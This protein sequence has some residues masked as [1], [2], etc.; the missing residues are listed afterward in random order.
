MNKQGRGTHSTKAALKKMIADFTKRKDGF[1]CMKNETIA[2]RLSKTSKTVANS[3]SMLKSNNEIEVLYIG[4]TRYLKLS[5][6]KK[7]NLDEVKKFYSTSGTD[8]GCKKGTKSGTPYKEYNNINKPKGSSNNNNKSV[9]PINVELVNELQKELIDF[10]GSIESYVCSVSNE[11]LLW[12]VINRYRKNKNNNI[13]S[14]TALYKHKVT[15]QIQL[16]IQEFQKS[17]WLFNW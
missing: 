1:F 5:G 3:I 10:R 17:T 15:E 12:E 6:N 7:E 11:K 16:T 2:K 8:S 13:Q 14:P 9:D 4:Q